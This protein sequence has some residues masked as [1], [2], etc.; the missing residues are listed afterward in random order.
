MGVFSSRAGLPALLL[1]L[2]G[3][4]KPLEAASYAAPTDQQAE[5]A[6]RGTL[7]AAYSYNA[8]K[9]AE[10]EPDTTAM[11]SVAIAAHRRA[12]D[13]ADAYGETLDG[14][15]GA[16]VETCAW[17]AFKPRTLKLPAYKGEFGPAPKGAWRCTLK[18]LHRAE[19]RAKP[20][21]EGRAE[22]FLFKTAEGGFAYFGRPA[23]F[24]KTEG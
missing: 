7:A 12:E 19:T 9:A 21:P 8:V 17:S 2:A 6:Y 24:A 1:L 18:V 5:A 14:F 20:R 22:G 16:E 15:Y 23:T 10:P 3:C 11:N 4:E 13:N